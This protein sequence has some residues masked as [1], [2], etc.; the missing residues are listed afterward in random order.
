[1]FQRRNPL[2]W[3]ARIAQLIWPTQGWRRAGS[4]VAH[5]LRRLP[6]TPY[7]IAAGFA[8]GAAVSFTPFIGLHFVL[9]G[10]LAMLLRGN[11]MAAAI[12]TVVGNPWTFPF[13]WWWIYGLGTWILGGNGTNG[14]PDELTF[15]YIFDNPLKVLVPMVVGAV[16]TATLAWFL[17]FWPLR[18]MVDRYQTAR[19]KRLQKKLE[20]KR[21]EAAAATAAVPYDHVAETRR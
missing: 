10:L 13:I 19:L 15:S 3:A 6:G 11:L 5:R 9:A 14:L 8:S 20:R 2:P 1:M 16:P 4:Y 12:G 7:R 18:R 17:C 21:R